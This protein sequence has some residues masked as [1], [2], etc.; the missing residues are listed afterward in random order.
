MIGDSN[1]P[2]S[3]F[4][5]QR[6]ALTLALTI[7]VVAAAFYVAL[8]AVGYPTHARLSTLA[9]VICGGAGVIGLLPVWSLS[10]RHPHGAAYGFMAGILFR[11]VVA[12]GAVVVAQWVLRMPDA[13]PLSMWI[14]GWYLIVLVVEVKLVS[15]HVLAAGTAVNATARGVALDP[16]S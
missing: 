2:L 3:V 8:G 6:G 12:G 14:A 13:Q 16:E 11:M 1:Q 5:I 15:S 9:A 7:A 10:R 4:P